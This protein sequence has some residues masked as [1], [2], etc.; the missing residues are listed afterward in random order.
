MV[1]LVWR[2]RVGVGRAWRCVVWVMLMSLLVMMLAARHGFLFGRL[3]FTGAGISGRGPG[4]AQRAAPLVA[5]G[6]RRFSGGRG[7]VGRMRAGVSAF[8]AP[9]TVQMALMILPFLT[10]LRDYW[11]WPASPAGSPPARG[12]FFGMPWAVLAAWFTLALGLALG[13]VIAR[14][15][16]EFGGGTHAPAGV[17]AG[18]RAADADLHLPGRQPAG[19][20]VAGGGVQ[21]SQR[22]ALR[23]GRGVV[24]AGARAW[25]LS[26]SNRSAGQQNGCC[27]D[28]AGREK[29]A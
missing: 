22:R 3:E 4:A 15:Q 23:R 28:K 29:K 13:L 6:G 17:G 20:P 7:P 10:R 24:P 8:T 9:V 5:D 1:G 19:G 27:D 25:T 16:L 26:R 21:R 2:E 11:R 12:A 14:R 18:R